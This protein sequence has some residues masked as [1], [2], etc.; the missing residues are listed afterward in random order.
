MEQLTLERAKRLEYGNY[1]H[2]TNYFNSNGSCQNWKINGKVK[3]WKTDPN[4][5][6][7]PI[8]RGLREF[9]YI[10]QDN[11]HEFH[12]PANCTNPKS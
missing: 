7:I 3:L 12:M 9:Y 2:A 10:T 6:E 4:R 5:I 11:L 8:K 1:V